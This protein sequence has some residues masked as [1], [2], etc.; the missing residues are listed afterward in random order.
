MT[1]IERKAGSFNE[2]GIGRTDVY[3]PGAQEKL[4]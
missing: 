2:E 4:S 3:L 1:K